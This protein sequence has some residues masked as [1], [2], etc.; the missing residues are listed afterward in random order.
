MKVQRVS[1]LVTKELKKLV[2]EPANLFMAIIFPIFMTVA[3]GAA[4]GGLGSGNMD[5]TYTVG[6]VDLDT[7]ANPVW[8]Q[9]FKEGISDGPSPVD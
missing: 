2:R 7:S 6:I 4:F 8:A 3:F 9:A 1:A 5:A